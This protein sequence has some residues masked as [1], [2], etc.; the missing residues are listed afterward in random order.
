MI[1]ANKMKLVQKELESGCCY[2]IVLGKHPWALAVQAPKI[3]GGRLHGGV[4]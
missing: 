1:Y 3:E 4:A 2:R